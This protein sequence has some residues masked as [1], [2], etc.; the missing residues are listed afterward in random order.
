MFSF[1]EEDLYDAAGLTE[2][3][4]RNRMSDLCIKVRRVCVY[5]GMLNYGLALS[6]CFINS[7]ASN[8]DNDPFSSD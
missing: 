8:V 2:T 3:V 5:S 7:F 1:H 4:R 6:S